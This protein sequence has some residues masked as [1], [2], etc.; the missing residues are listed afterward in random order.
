VV[1]KIHG[2]VCKSFLTRESE[3][4]AKIGVWLTKL[5]I[6]QVI[7]LS[8]YGM[9]VIS[10]VSNLTRYGDNIVMCGEKCF[11]MFMRRLSDNNSKRT[12]KIV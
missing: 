8:I 1:E 11:S 12:T 3:K 5:S 6:K 7:S 9:S 4:V 2:F 10:N